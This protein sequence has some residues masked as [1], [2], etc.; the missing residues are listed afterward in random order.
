MNPEKRRKYDEFGN[1]EP[2]QHYRHYRQYYQEDV[3]AEVDLFDDERLNIS[4]IGY[5]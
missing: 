2:E 3:S 1:E 5:F 4:Y